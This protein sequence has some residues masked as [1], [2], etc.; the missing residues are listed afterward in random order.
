MTFDPITQDIDENGYDI[1]ADSSGLVL[2]SAGAHLNGMMYHPAMNEDDRR[3]VIVLLHGFP[4]HERNFDLA[5]ILRRAGWH[6]LV[7]HYRGSW[8][9]TGDY[10]FAHARADVRHVIDYLRRDQIAAQHRIDPERIITV[11]HSLGGWA[12]LMTAAEGIVTAAA[13]L[14]AVNM[15]LWGTLLKESPAMVRPM[16]QSLF[17]ENIAPLQGVSA[18]QLVDEVTEHGD[19]WHLERRADA[20][21]SKHLLMI[22]G[23]RDELVSAFDHHLPVVQQIKTK[24]AVH[25]QSEL[26]AAGHGFDNQRVAIARLLLDWLAGLPA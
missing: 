4:G 6:T 26:L 10:R 22:A 18:D 15:G 2:P 24:G 19:A 3:G 11:G 23:K 21:Q 5:Q 9:S 8:G 25:L 14:A 20:L 7:F 12:S 16:V 1:K 13:S 17:E